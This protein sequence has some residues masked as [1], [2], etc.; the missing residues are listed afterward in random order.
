[1]RCAGKFQAR[2]ARN[3][4]R[5]AL[6]QAKF[7][8]GERAALPHVCCAEEFQA[9]SAEQTRGARSAPTGEIWTWGARSAPA[10]VLCGIISLISGAKRRTRGARRAPTGEIWTWGGFRFTM[11]QVHPG[12]CFTANI[13]RKTRK[14]NKPKNSK[15]ILA[16]FH[17]LRIIYINIQKYVCGFIITDPAHG[18]C[19]NTTT[20]VAS[21][22]SFVE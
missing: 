16:K 6:P 13:Y 18:G 7:G 1:M 11:S 20:P 10:C 4:E 22:L 17:K 9:R 19:F 2:S 15:C 21:L 8:R 3:A 12:V 14:R 5:E